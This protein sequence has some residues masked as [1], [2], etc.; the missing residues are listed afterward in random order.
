RAHFLAEVVLEEV[1]D[2]E[3]AARI[4]FLPDARSD[5]EREDQRAEARA[6]VPPPCG[7]AIAIGMTCG[8]NRRAGADVGREKRRKEQPRTERSAGDKKLGRAA[9]AAADVRAQEDQP[10]GE[11][12]EQDVEEHCASA[13]VGSRWIPRQA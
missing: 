10:D 6:A 7:Q 1:A 9:N 8:T 2:R 12:D 3:Q 5:P 13:D 4:R 11:D